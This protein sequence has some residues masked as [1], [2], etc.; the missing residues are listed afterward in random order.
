M[1]QHSTKP[2]IR[3]VRPP[4]TQI[5]LC[6]HAVGSVFADGMWSLK[7][8]GYPKRD[9]QEPLPYWVDVQSDLSLSR[10]HRSN[11]RFSHVLAQ[12]AFE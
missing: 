7:P 9:E 5:S 3:L 8:S 2:T 10:S 1:S 4:K 11:C 12:M 6:I